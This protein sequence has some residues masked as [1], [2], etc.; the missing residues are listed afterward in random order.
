MRA[1]K[2]LGLQLSEAHRICGCVYAHVQNQTDSVGV[3]M[4]MY[5]FG[6]LRQTERG[7]RKYM[8]M[9]SIKTA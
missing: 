5:R 4:H 3:Y 2:P 9:H 7:L 8:H 6:Q 1:S